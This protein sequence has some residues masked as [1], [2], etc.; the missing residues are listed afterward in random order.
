MSHIM[1]IRYIY[2]YEKRRG[3][4]WITLALLTGLVNRFLSWTVWIPLGRLTF[5]AYLL[6]PILMY[7]MILTK[8]VAIHWTYVEIVG[9][10]YNGSPSHQIMSKVF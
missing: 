4:N 3:T 8:K 2:Y 6:H 9:I 5:G 1:H 10:W 7:W